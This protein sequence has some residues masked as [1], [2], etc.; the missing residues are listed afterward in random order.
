ML[1][2]VVLLKL[3]I[4]DAIIKADAEFSYKKGK[5]ILNLKIISILIMK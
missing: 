4:D 2:Q 3:K 1:L 5:D